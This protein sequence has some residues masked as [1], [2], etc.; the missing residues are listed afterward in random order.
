[1]SLKIFCSCTL[2]LFVVQAATADAQTNPPLSEVNDYSRGMTMKPTLREPAVSEVNAKGGYSGGRMNSEEAH[3]FEA[4]LTF[5]ITHSI[6]FQADA[7]YSRISNEDFYGGAG[8]LFWRDPDM[9]LVGLTGGYLYRD[10][11]NTYHVGAE[12]EYYFGRFT[13]G[14]F[15]GVS[16]IHYDTAAPFIDTSV[17]RFAGAASVDYYLLDDLRLGVTYM[18]AFEDNLIKGDMEYQTPIRN[19]AVTAEV[20]VGDHGYDH[21]L[22]GVRYYFGGNKSLRD[23]QRRDDPRSLMP[24]V[25]HGLGVYGAEFNRKGNAYLAA[26]PGAGSLGGGGGSFGY[27]S[28]NSSY[29]WRP[30]RIFNVDGSY[31]IYERN[32][33]GELVLLGTYPPEIR[34]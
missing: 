16:S 13:F 20:A 9:G 5:P 11:V 24:Q 19:V 6:G 12:G 25:L 21:W 22:V 15:A 30:I 17:T 33:F 14:F 8:H 32:A 26:N 27:E 31:S 3:N 7:L 29:Y 10:G 18:T 28:T 1:M 4:S 34:P 2:F 23:R